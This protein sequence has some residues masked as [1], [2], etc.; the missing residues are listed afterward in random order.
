MTSSRRIAFAGLSATLL[1]GVAV[2][3][4]LAGDN[5]SGSSESDAPAAQLADASPKSFA[6][7][8][9]SYGEETTLARAEDGSELPLVL[10]SVEEANDKN[11][12]GVFSGP[13]ESYSF[14]FPIA[15]ESSKDLRTP[16]VVIIESP[17][18]YG[19]SASEYYEGDLKRNPFEGKE[20]CSVGGLEAV[21]INARSESDYERANAAYV[22]FRL[23]DLEVQV[24]A[25]DNLDLAKQVAESIVANAGVKN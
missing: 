14:V 24:T 11:L 17:W 8:V 20:L 19:L 7:L 15:N 12:V 25:G 5:Q 2:V 6:R 16:E 18:D 13:G 9:A 22:G 1:I 10:P 23:G 4:L 21:C 3:V